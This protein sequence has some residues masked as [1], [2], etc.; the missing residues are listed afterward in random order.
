MIYFWLLM[1]VYRLPFKLTVYIHIHIIHIIHIHIEHKRDIGPV[2]CG[3]DGES[4]K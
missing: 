1:N 4:N 3:C 2:H